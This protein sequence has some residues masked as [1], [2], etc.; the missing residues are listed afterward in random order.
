MLGRILA[1]AVLASGP[2]LPAK[3]AEPISDWTIERSDARCVAVRRFGTADKPT[4]LALKASPHGDVFQ[5]AIL[6]SGFRKTYLQSAATIRIDGESFS[7]T[8]LSYPLGGDVRRVAHLIN[9]D[10]E[11]SV[12]LRTAKNLHATIVEGI[13]DSFDMGQTVSLWKD[14]GDC[15]SRLRETWNIGEARA[16]RIAEPA[17][18]NLRPL[19]SGDDYPIRAILADESGSTRIGLLIDEKGLVRDCTLIEASGIARL[20]SRSCAIISER[21]KFAPARDGAG[22]PVKSSWT[23]TITWRLAG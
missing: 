13:N 9:L 19:F 17:R 8:A 6:R 20:D 4:T 16:Q 14:M 10:E 2:S 15:I 22:K 23:Q 5:L 7:T 21:A 12:A 3:A 11:T 1:F 18:G